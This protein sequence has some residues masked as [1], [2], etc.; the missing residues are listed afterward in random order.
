MKKCITRN[1][2]V[3]LNQSLKILRHVH[4]FCQT[5]IS[6]LLSKT[7]DPNVGFISASTSLKSCSTQLVTYTSQ[8]L[9]PLGI[10]SVFV[11]IYVFCSCILRSSPFK[12]KATFNDNR[13][14]VGTDIP[15][16]CTILLVLFWER[17]IWDSK[18]IKPP[19]PVFLPAPYHV[20]V[21]T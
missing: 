5:A 3:I 17:L 12:R 15:L 19:L 9:Q 21:V 16:A 7:T 13:V 4:T 8:K 14:S 2:H 18:S 11:F 20:A 1:Y 10:F 6:R